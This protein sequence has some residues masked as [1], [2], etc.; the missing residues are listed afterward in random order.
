MILAQ[1]LCGVYLLSMRSEMSRRQGRCDEGAPRRGRPPTISDEAILDVAREVFLEKGVR[2]TAADVAQRAAISEGTIFNRFGTKEALFRKALRYDPSSEPTVLTNLV[3]RAG[4][5][6]LRGLLVEI[7]LELLERGMLALPLMMMEWS[8][9][10]GDVVLDRV[11]GGSGVRIGRALHALSAFFAEERRRGRIGVRAN[12]DVVARMF[13]GGLH[14][15]CLQQILTAD[16][17]T[18]ATRRKFVRGV[19]DILLAG[20]AGPSVASADETADPAT[21]DDDPQPRN[22]LMHPIDGGGRPPGGAR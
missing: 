2:A 9:P 4:E 13:A 10:T 3:S 5:G 6:A 17:T 18:R 16:R 12:P 19:V 8:N 11:A 1:H 22:T 20:I 14:Q 15:F 21:T 7:G